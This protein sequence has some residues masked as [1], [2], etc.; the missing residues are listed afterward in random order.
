MLEKDLVKML[1][2]QDKSVALDEILQGHSTNVPVMLI[3]E[4]FTVKNLESLMKFR[5]S[6]RFDFET[7]S[8]DDFVGYAEEFDQV[9]AKCFVDPDR[10]SAEIVF[11]I[12]TE[13]QPLHQDHTASLKLQ[14]TSA[15]SA[16]LNLHGS[17]MYQKDS[18]DFIEDFGEF[19]EVIANDN[20][21]MSV[22]QAANAINKITIEAARSMTSEVGDF[23]ESMSA[24]EKAEVKGAK[25]FPSVLLFTCTPY[26]GLS[27]REFMVKISVLTGEEKPRLSFRVVQLETHQ[28]DIANEF[29][30]ILVG[31]F[32]GKEIKTLIGNGSRKG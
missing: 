8:I 17:K 6:Y 7:K 16:F 5:S 18:S 20:E 30:E 4:G 3:P 25:K 15:Y 19:I 14:K 22:G 13:E 31:K 23:S 12:G 1:Q 32:D 24:M 27:K 26:T 11:D 9:G 2:Q 29:K 28:E 10:V 21:K